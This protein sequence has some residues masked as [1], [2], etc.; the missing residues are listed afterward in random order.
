MQAYIVI[1]T[2]PPPFNENKE[3]C[4]KELL[5][6]NMIEFITIIMYHPRYTR[7]A[8]NFEILIVFYSLLMNSLDV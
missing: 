7:W 6:I 8:S 5:S 3:V 2:I 1:R 4:Y